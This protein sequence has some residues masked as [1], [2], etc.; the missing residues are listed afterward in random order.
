[1][2]SLYKCTVYVNMHSLCKYTDYF[3]VQSMKIHTLCK[4]VHCTVNVQSI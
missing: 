4:Y 2:Y 1:M 3:N